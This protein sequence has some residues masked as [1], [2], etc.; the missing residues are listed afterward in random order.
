[1]K[2]NRRAPL[3]LVG[4]S[5]V[6]LALPLTA[7]DASTESNVIPSDN[8][9]TGKFILT[10]KDAARIVE[11]TLAEALR[12][13]P[14]SVEAI[15]HVPD[16]DVNL[17]PEAGDRNLRFMNTEQLKEKARKEG[18]LFYYVLN[19]DVR[20]ASAVTVVS[21]H[22]MLDEDNNPAFCISGI[23]FVTEFERIEDKLEVKSISGFLP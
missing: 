1:M 8:S 15:V 9:G 16:V 18:Y 4:L 19:I 12:H 11:L 3:S 10:S 22:V 21:R 2:S 20:T 14:D 6:I 13:K 5:L 23:G 17:L 7:E